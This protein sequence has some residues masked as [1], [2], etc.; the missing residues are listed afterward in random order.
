MVSVEAFDV[1]SDVCCLTPDGS[2]VCVTEDGSSG[3]SVK[4]GGSTWSVAFTVM[5]SR[6]HSS[7]PVTDALWVNALSS[8]TTVTT[9]IHA[10]TM[11]SVVASE[12]KGK[13][14]KDYMLNT[15]WQYHL[16]LHSHCFCV[17]GLMALKSQ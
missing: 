8:V 3:V 11:A 2:S 5:F 6:V 1:N 9:F 7:V 12:I 15:I 17:M 4:P 14:G 10:V 16:F 13:H